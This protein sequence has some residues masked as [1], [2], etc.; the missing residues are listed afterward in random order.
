[1]RG[2]I[3]VKREATAFGI[4]IVRLTL[5]TD[6]SLRVLLFLAGKPEA[7]ATISEMAD[8]YNI[9]RNHLVKVVHNLGRLGYVVTS[10]GKNGGVKLARSAE[11]IS[12]SDVVKKVE[13]DMD[14]L[15]CFNPK[16]DNCAISRICS[17]KSMIYEGRSAFMN[18]LDQYSLADAAKP[19]GKAKP[20]YVN[21]SQLK[22]KG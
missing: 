18:V 20:A 21:I 15:E 5:Y 1:V 6:Y 16:T 17:L 9:S 14:L 12:I 4:Y 7:T 11:D 22:R 2:V 19:L 8:F 10:R 13:P 3:F